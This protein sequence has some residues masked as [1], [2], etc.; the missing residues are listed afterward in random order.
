VVLDVEMPVLGGI[1]AWPR[2]REGAPNA[3]VLMYSSHPEF[4]EEALAAGASTYRAKDSN[5]DELTAVLVELAS[6]PDGAP[7]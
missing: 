1:D 5:L 2:L 4:A 7:A 6:T 3:R